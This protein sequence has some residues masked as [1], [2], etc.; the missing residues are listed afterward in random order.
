VERLQAERQL[1]DITES[2]TQECDGFACVFVYASLSSLSGLHMKRHE[3][4]S[5]SADP[6]WTV[7]S[8]SAALLGTQ[9]WTA[10]CSLRPKLHHLRQIESRHC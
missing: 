4:S 6:T 2:E 1:A 7:N 9:A 8:I 10:A 3:T 5:K